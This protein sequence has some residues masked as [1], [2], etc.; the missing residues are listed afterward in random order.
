T[1]GLTALLA[2]DSAKAKADLQPAAVPAPPPPA[3]YR[4]KDYHCPLCLAPTESG[5]CHE[6]HEREADYAAYHGQEL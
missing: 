4:P 2:H 6:C 3:S 1:E 5:L